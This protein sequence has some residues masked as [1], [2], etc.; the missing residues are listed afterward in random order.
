MTHGHILAWQKMLVLSFVGRPPDGWAGL[1][2]SGGRRLCVIY[3]YTLVC[4]SI[5]FFIIIMITTTTT[6]TVSITTIIIVCRRYMYMAGLSVRACAAD[7]ANGIYLRHFRHLNHR[8]PDR[9]QV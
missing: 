4:M 5:P 2:C 1:P 6:T 8:I 7:Y 9:H 3:I